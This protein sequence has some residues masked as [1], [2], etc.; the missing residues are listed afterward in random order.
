MRSSSGSKT[1]RQS[2]S[3]SHSPGPG[4]RPGERV[5]QPHAAVAHSPRRRRCRTTRT[6]PYL[7]TPGNHDFDNA[8]GAVG[9]FDTYFPVSRYAQAVNDSTTK[10]GG[11]LGQNQFGTDPIDRRNMDN[12]NLFAAGTDFVL[13]LEWRRPTLRAG[14]RPRARR[15]P[16]PHR[17]HGDAQLPDGVGE[18]VDGD[19]AS[20]R[21][22]SQ[23]ALW[24]NFVST[25]CQI[26]IV[27]AGHEHNGDDGE[28]N[29][30]DA[31][32]CGSRSTS[33]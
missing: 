3:A 23:A 22:G 12:Y 31:N 9:P 27:I 21:R 11:H 10:Y 13:N 29:R 25:H 18:P 14:G 20:G 16:R 26:R 1:Y 19:A 8:T 28:A 33:S 6:S 24:N 32:S 4:G 5:H 7:V 2:S 15:E 30:T 17:D